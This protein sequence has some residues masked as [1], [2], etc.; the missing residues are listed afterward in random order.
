MPPTARR[1]GAD[2][3]LGDAGLHTNTGTKKSRLRCA[4]SARGLETGP[5]PDR[6][7]AELLD[8]TNLLNFQYVSELTGP[9]I[10]VPTKGANCPRGRARGSLAGTKLTRRQFFGLRIG[11]AEGAFMQTR[12]RKILCLLAALLLAISLNAC[13]ARAVVGAGAFAAK[14]TVKAGAVAVRTTGRAVG[15]AGRAVTN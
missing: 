4:N 1:K 7:A 13:A 11:P 8:M 6:L 5:T 10:G 14:T 15:A 2:E 3:A 12:A 9:L